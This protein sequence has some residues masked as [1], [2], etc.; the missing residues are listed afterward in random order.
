M[1][2]QIS[3]FTHGLL[4][5]VM[6]TALHYV[7]RSHMETSNNSEPKL[8][9]RFDLGRASRVVREAW[10]AMKRS[11][12]LNEVELARAGVWRGPAT[13][14]VPSSQASGPLDRNGVLKIDVL[15]DSEFQL[16]VQLR[17]LTREVLTPGERTRLDAI[18]VT[19]DDSAVAIHGLYKHIL[20][21]IPKRS[22]AESSTPA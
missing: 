19:N 16:A 4:W 18:P 13:L 6:N 15:N 3:G 14:V 1:N 2:T 8:P 11:D 10:R 5:R 9:S 21:A 12:E 7:A 17:I 22:E 20:E